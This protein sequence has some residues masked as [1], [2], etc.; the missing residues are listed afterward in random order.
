MNRWEIYLV[1]ENWNW[2]FGIYRGSLYVHTILLHIHT[3]YVTCT[4]HP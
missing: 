3:K 2:N 4:Y 1:D